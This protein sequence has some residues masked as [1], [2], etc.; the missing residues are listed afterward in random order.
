[1]HI[2]GRA[3]DLHTMIAGALL[4]IVG[5]QVVSLGLAAH[6]YG[7]YFMGEKDPWFD[8]M[9]ERFALEHGLLLGGGVALVGLVLGA[10]IVGEWIS[11]SFAQLSEQRLA[12]AAATLLIVGVQIFFSSFLLSILGLRRED[13]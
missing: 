1:V 12:V 7:S 4:T 6:A 5:T 11:R 2:F 8:R 13:R 10:I 3:W 9:R